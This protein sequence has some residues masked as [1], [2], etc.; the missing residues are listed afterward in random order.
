MSEFH[1]KLVQRK[2]RCGHSETS[3]RWVPGEAEAA[4]GMNVLH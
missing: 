4:Q 1:H 2:V 3:L